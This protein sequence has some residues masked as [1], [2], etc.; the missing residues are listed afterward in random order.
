MKQ[1]YDEYLAKAII[2]YFLDDNFPAETEYK[3]IMQVDF[4]DFLRMNI[5][6]NDIVRLFRIIKNRDG[7]IAALGVDLL[8]KYSKENDD[9]INF[10]KEIWDSSDNY[11]KCHLFWRILDDPTL[12]EDWHKK[13]YSF[14]LNNW[15]IFKEV[16]K[17]FWGSS[18]R[19]IPS[20][21]KNYLLM[22][23]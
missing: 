17:I 10:L 16:Q 21:Q 20:V 14:A 5:D 18:S 9:V 22:N 4:I 13:L 8:K 12:S 11:L 15:E 7:H 19:I 3:F 2:C 1:F 23:T 6:E